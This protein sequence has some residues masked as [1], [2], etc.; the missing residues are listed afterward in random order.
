MTRKLSACRH[1]DDSLAD[2]GGPGWNTILGASRRRAAQPACALPGRAYAESAIET[3]GPRLARPVCTVHGGHGPGPVR[4]IPER[5][6][7]RD[8][9][10]RG[11]PRPDS[12]VHPTRGSTV[13]WGGPRNR[14]RGSSLTAESRSEDSSA[15]RKSP[16]PLPLAIYTLACIPFYPP[17]LTCMRAGGV[18]YFLVH[19]LPSHLRYP[20]GRANCYQQ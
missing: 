12:G 17:A 14:S 1:H 10:G 15:R 9:L 4:S 6:R 19:N 13:S 16:F 2:R 5:S 7:R 8:A 3:P 18:R 20:K 11:G